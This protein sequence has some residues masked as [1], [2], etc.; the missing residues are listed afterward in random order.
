MPRKRKCKSCREWFY[1]E[2]PEALVCSAECA[3]A[4]HRLE[5][6]K[7]LERAHRAQKRALKTR[8][9]WITE[10]QTVFN[11]YIRLRDALLPCVSCGRYHEGK[12]NAGH[13][14]TTAAAPELRF[15][16]LNCHKQCEPC[17][18]HLSGNITRYREELIRRIGQDQVEWLEGPHEPK[19][20][21]IE[22]L[23]EIKKC[24]QEKLKELR[25]LS[26]VDTP[27]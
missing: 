4:Y 26:V 6:L 21:T 18:S 27:F 1:P 3:L 22:E 8:Q 25:Q 14:R 17:N 23:I 5:Q 16:E 13:F 12:W 19:K 7:A 24:Y 10:V 15:N 9:Q 11:R 20:Y 2:P